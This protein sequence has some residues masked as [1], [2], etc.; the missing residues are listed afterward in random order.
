MRP[1]NAMWW[2]ARWGVVCRLLLVALLVALLAGCGS[3]VTSYVHPNV[4]FGHV[5]RVAVIPF[6]N[7]TTDRAAAERMQSIFLVEILKENVLEMVDTRETSAAMNSLGMPLGELLTP[8]QAVSLGLRLGVDALLFGVVEE[9]GFARGGRQKGPVVT[10]TFGMVETETGVEIW[11]A[12]AHKT[13]SSL[14]KR[15]F[16]GGANDLYSVSRDVVRD[17][18]KTLL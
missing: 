3:S 8:E 2:R 15:L 18:L 10:A 9:Y 4:D 5:Q 6:A 7:L 16:G 14:W 12:N 1:P 13:G 11:R 17:A